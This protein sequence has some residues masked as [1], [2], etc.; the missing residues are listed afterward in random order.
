SNSI[1][2][3]EDITT[4][5][6]SFQDSIRTDQER[7]DI[8]SDQMEHLEMLK[9]KYGGSLESVLTYKD[10]IEAELLSSSDYDKRIAELEK[11]L[12]DYHKQYLEV[13]LKLRS[14]R[15][16]AAV[17]FEKEVIHIL[18]AL[19]LQGTRFS[20]NLQPLT[21][22]QMTQLGLDAAEFFIS[23]NPGEEE[24]P[25]AKTASGGEISRIML[26]IKMVLQNRDSIKTMIFD[27]IDSGISGSTAQKVGNILLE[28]AEYSQVICITHLSQIASKGQ[29]H[30][31]IYKDIKDGRVESYVRTLTGEKRIAEIAGLISGKT[32]TDSS[33]KQAKALLV[34]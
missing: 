22:T 28:L 29:H 12:A 19:D 33:L 13:A 16:T 34:E 1:P 3:V 17:R 30:F 24:R 20:V 7:L 27:E 5:I 8:V 18:G 23:T 4:D 15:H 14:K 21:D 32:V 2:E 10:S 9:R 26:A 31:K 11:L 6:A 25:L